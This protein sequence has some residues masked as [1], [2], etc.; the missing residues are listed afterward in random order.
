M[1]S[2]IPTLQ[3]MK[4][5]Y[6]LLVLLTVSPSL[7]QA[8]SS[9]QPGEA[10]EYKVRGGYPE[11]WLIGRFIRV[12]PGGSQ[13]LIHGAPS[14]FFPEGPEIAYA[15][16]DLRRPTGATPALVA[17]VART[18]ESRPAP[19]GNSPALANGKGLLGAEELISLAHQIM[20]ATPY[21][22]SRHRELA[23]DQIRDIVKARGTD[24]T[25]TA[26]S[27][28]SN[29][30][31]AQGTMSTHIGYAINSNRGPAPKLSDYI[32]TFH[33]RAA[34]RGSQSAKRDGAKVTVTTT[35]AQYESGAL[36]INP[37]GTYVWAYLR[38]APAE[39]WRHGKW[40][41]ANADE[42]LPWEAGP[43]IWLLDAK[44]GSDYMVRMSRE[45]GWSGWIDVG[46]GKGRTPVEYG[47]RP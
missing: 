5:H 2:R 27:D 32:G 14:Q 9:Y 33:L 39:Q 46:A 44:Q 6:C 30:M 3:F 10:V 15:P 41:A 17:E 13:Y 43:A 31:H 38:G 7:S 8:Q 45:P 19:T 23:L 25:Y 4:I 47:R 36:T 11:Q 34:N 20:G 26:V 12:L 16:I 1:V 37:D 18:V 40:R 28:F 24:F 42:F 29:R 21:A 22:D 35:D